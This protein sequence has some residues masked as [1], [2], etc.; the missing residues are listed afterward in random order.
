MSQEKLSVR[1]DDKVRELNETLLWRE[2]K[3][4]ALEAQRDYFRKLA[5]SQI[6]LAQQNG[7]RR[8]STQVKYERENTEFSRH[9]PFFF[10]ILICYLCL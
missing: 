4:K 2:N 7:S 9:F 6:P 3:I 1:Q 10:K 5:Q 8:N